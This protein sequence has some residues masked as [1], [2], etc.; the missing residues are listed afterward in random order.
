ME[1]QEMKQA[2]AELSEKLDKVYVSSEKMR[3]YFLW[4]LIISVVLFVLPL[5]GLVF[6][7]PSFINTYSTI[8]NI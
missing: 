2:I 4:T 3:K 5:I 6:A 8:S 7:I 1:E